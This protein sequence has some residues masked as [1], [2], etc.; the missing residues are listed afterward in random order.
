MVDLIMWAVFLVAFA[1]L[2]GLKAHE[3]ARKGGK[4]HAD[5]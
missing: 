2:V 5:S 3:L 1:L 4:D